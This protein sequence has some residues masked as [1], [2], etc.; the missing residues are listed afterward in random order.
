MRYLAVSTYL[1][2]TILVRL[3]LLFLIWE[4]LRLFDHICRLSDVLN[5]MIFQFLLLRVFRVSHSESKELGILIKYHLCKVL[6]ALIGDPHNRGQ[7]RSGTKNKSK[8]TATIKEPLLR[9]TYTLADLATQRQVVPLRTTAGSEEGISQPF[10]PRP[11]L[12]AT[13]KTPF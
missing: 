10:L 13:L 6:L 11:S 1:V 9:F 7:R 8:Q 4:R 2:E 5:N 12:S 3:L